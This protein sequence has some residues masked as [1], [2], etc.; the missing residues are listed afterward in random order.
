MPSIMF[1]SYMPSKYAR[2]DGAS[3]TGRRRKRK[4]SRLDSDDFGFVYAGESNVGSIKR[5]A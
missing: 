4:K 3:A 2:K 5:L 1:T